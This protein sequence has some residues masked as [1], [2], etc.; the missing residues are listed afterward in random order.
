MSDTKKTCVLILGAG[1]GGIYAAL[2]L[3]RTLAERGDCE[4][5]LVDKTNFTLF[6]PMLHEVAASDLD[7]SDIVNPIR[8]MLRNVTFYEATVD[9]IDLQA[10]RVTVVYGLRRKKRELIYDHLVLALGSDT[11]FF[12]DQTKANALQ[13]KT[14]TD[15]IFLRNRMIGMLESATV[16]EDADVRRRLMTFVVA[17][18][19]FAGV[20]T[21]GAMNDFLRDAVKSYPKLDAKLLR[22]I[23]V[24]P[25]D[26][27]LPEFSK[28]LGEYTT[29]RLRDAGIDVRLNTKV[30]TY[31]GHTV[32]LEPGDPLPSSTLLWTA[33][34][35]P[36]QLVQNLPLKKEKGR[37]VVN[38]CMQSEEMPSV[39]CLGDSA[40]VPDP[41]HEGKAYP[42]TAQHAIRQGPVLAKNIEA[43]V[44][45]EGRQ[46]KP[47][48]Y[49]MLGQL[50]A[51]GQ[52][53]GAAQILG[54]NFS[55]FFAWFLWRSAYLWKLPRI[56]KKMR[57]A[58]G[59]T[60]DLLFSRDLVQLMTVEEVQ[61]IAAFAKRYQL[62]PGEMKAD[63][64][65]SKPA[66]RREA[67]AQH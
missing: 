39:W 35:M 20:E 36:S 13:M 51:I 66:E 3:D 5:V 23:L 56:E 11:R 37:I 19:G 46:Q 33:G 34:V 38:G 52:R 57:V 63:E 47:F 49:K 54:I 4:V 60:I 62:Q 24:H 43:A 21:I 15:A 58:F 44:L 8:R 28:S 48:K 10:K 42:A 2:R 7:P 31:D 30:K 67:I 25:G 9:A 26:V 12:D 59:W 27:L 45:G 41:Y 14:L 53:R 17:G 29:A 6:T 18:G 65:A 64:P 40:H 50:A 22:I 1:F 16:E 61:R 32:E 55:G